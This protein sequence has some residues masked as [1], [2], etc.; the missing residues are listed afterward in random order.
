VRIR[1]L[2]VCLASAM[3]LAPQAGRAGSSRRVALLPIVV[4]S[5]AKDSVYLSDG[6]A[7]MLAARLERGG[8][9]SVTRI[10]SNA[11]STTKLPVA[12]EAGRAAGADYVVFGSF[13]QF[14]SGA[15]LDVQ[16]ARVPPS[17]ESGGAGP[18]RIFIQSGSL[19]EI[20]PELDDL[21]DKIT[22]FLDGKAPPSSPRAPAASA[23][24]DPNDLGGILRRLD[25]LERAVYLDGAAAPGAA[26]EA[27][28][29][30]DAESG[31]GAVSA[32]QGATPLR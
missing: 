1:I 21:A 11:R 24:S 8:A 29:A 7:D 31:G 4:H 22:R 27:D 5:A 14:G 17:G 6:L 9:V 20:I 13:T 32:E 28:V 23:S 30:E 19:G 2:A 3:L 18:R 16:C 15:S 12:V 10:Q 26:G 25:A